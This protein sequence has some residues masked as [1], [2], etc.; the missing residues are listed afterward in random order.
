MQPYILPYLGYFQLMYDVDKFVI[1]DN[2]QFTKKGWIHRNRILSN[3]KDALFTLPIKKD[4]DYLNVN[5]RF[6]SEAFEGEKKKILRRITESYRKAPYFEEVYPLV[7]TIFNN[8]QNNLFDFIYFSICEITKFIGIDVEIIKSSELYPELVELKGQDKVLGICKV[9]NGTHYVNAIGGKELYAKDV[10]LENNI[11]LH[12]LNSELK[13]YKQFKN[14]F[15]PGL[16]IVDVLMFNSVTELQ[17]A[18]NNYSYE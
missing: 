3:G 7:E 16:S 12:F 9:L 17:T 11:K 1:Y 5:E 14:K 15:V 2:I 6:L 13:P 10:F 18:L 4:S 8:K